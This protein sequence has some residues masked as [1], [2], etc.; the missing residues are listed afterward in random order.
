M[1][2]DLSTKRNIKIDHR[3]NW[4]IGELKKFIRSI[5]QRIWKFHE[6]QLENVN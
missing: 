6:I 3:S 5:N 2:K 4:I 1:N